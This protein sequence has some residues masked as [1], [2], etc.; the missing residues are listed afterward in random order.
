M[1]AA[2]PAFAAT[3]PSAGGEMQMLDPAAN[4]TQGLGDLLGGAAVDPA[5]GELRADNPAA[6][7]AKV[8]KVAQGA[9]SML[10]GL[11]AGQPVG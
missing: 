5:T 11:P 8:D 6:V 1:G 2:S 10:G 4:A 7:T 9:V 3:Q